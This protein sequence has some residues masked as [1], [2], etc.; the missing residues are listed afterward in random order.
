MVLADGVPAD[1]VLADGVLADG[2]LADEM[3]QLQFARSACAAEK[4]RCW[5]A[6]AIREILPTLFCDLLA[7]YYFICNCA[8]KFLFFCCKICFL[9]HFIQKMLAESVLACF[10]ANIV[11]PSLAAQSRELV[12]AGMRPAPGRPAAHLRCTESAK[13]SKK[14]TL[15]SR[16]H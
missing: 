1:G 3:W 4:S 11:S 14:S 12:S 13:Q 5:H 8:N 7:F 6:M 10:L 15:P 16:R 9:L 2:V